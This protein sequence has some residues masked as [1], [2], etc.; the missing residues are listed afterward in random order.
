[1]AKAKRKT[2]KGHAGKPGPEIALCGAKNK[3]AGEIGNTGKVVP[4]TCRKQ[5]GWGTDHPGHGR[6]R[7][8]GGSTPAQKKGVAVEVAKEAVAVFGLPRD[9]DPHAALL[10]ELCRTAGHVSWLGEQVQSLEE[11]EMYGPV[12]SET[13][14]RAEPHVWIRLYQ[15]ER[16]HLTDVAAACVKAGIEERR[17]T[18]AEQ[19]GMMIAQVLRGVL[20]ELGIAFE[21]AQPLLRKHLAVMEG[22]GRELGQG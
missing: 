19:Q 17:V 21:Q 20:G 13:Y 14:P 10:E 15:G 9:I 6:C 11:G 22:T 3:R 16:K 8:H 2:Q 18:L 1:M 12:G 7:L 4:E 5:A